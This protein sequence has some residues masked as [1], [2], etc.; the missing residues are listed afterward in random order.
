[1]RLQTAHEVFAD[2]EGNV[3]VALDARYVPTFEDVQWLLRAVEREGEP[4]RDVAHVLVNL[5]MYRR[6][7]GQ[8]GSSLASLVRAYAQ[9]VNPRWFP[10]GDKHLERVRNERDER[11]VRLLEAVARDRRDEHSTR[12]HFRETT[13]AAVRAALSESYGRDWTD[14]AAPTFD[15]SVRGYELRQAGQKAD[16]ARREPAKNAFW[17]R[18]PGWSGYAVERSG[19]GGVG[20]GALVALALLGGA[21]WLLS[22]YA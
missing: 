17:T 11:M 13:A 12:T 15:A 19:G 20:Q 4:V 18:A 10:D 7:H 6:A 9:P 21:A 16:Y 5:F 3:L 14:Y 1:M 2:V 22:S 8:G